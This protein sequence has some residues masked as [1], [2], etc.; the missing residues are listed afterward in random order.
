MYLTFS[1]SRITKGLFNAPVQFIVL[2]RLFQSWIVLSTGKSLSN[3]YVSQKLILRYPLD[4]DLS[5]GLGCLPFEQMGSDQ[6]STWIIN[7]LE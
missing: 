1:T 6:P 4:G 2:P 7:I 3:G 5:N